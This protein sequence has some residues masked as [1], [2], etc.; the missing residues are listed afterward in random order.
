MGE[1]GKCRVLREEGGGKFRKMKEGGN[2]TIC[3]SG[4]ATRKDTIY[5]I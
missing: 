3:T 4:K 2:I 5:I 1:Q